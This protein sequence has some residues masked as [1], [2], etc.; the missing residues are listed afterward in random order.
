MLKDK[1]DNLL[2]EK[3]NNL[4]SL[5]KIDYDLSIEFGKAPK[6]GVLI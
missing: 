6:S 3:P 2:Q 5:L 4:Q 1:A